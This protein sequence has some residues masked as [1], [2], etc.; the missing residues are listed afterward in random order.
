M[1][2]QVS[3][4]SPSFAAAIVG[5]TDQDQS[6]SLDGTVLTEMRQASQPFTDFHDQGL[7]AGAN[8]AQGMEGPLLVTLSS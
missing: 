7:R 5:E 2:W 8:V 1:P 3:G 6:Q 4:E